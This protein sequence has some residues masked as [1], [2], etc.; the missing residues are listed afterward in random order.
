MLQSGAALAAIVTVIYSNVVAQAVLVDSTEPA[1]GQITGVLPVFIHC[2]TV[3]IAPARDC[4]P[5]VSVDHLLPS[6]W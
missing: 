5:Q 2:T 6:R 3:S 4:V 1:A